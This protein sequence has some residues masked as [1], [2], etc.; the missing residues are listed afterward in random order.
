L[1]HHAV[2]AEIWLERVPVLE[3]ALAAT[4]MGIRSTLFPANAQA[5]RD[6]DAAA[7]ARASDTYPL[8]FDPQTSGGLL[9]A[10]PPQRTDACVAALRSAGYRGAVEIG[11]VAESIGGPP[12]RIVEQP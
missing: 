6:I 7:G 3:G 4:R 10:I 11:R 2:A 5:E 9:A 1:K 8:L 12:V